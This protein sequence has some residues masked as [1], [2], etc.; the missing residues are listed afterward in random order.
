MQHSQRGDPALMAAHL[1]DEAEKTVLSIPTQSVW[2]E[3]RDEF[4][5]A[6]RLWEAADEAFADA[7]PTSAKGAIA[8][9]GALAEMLRSIPVRD[10]SL[11][12]RHVRALIAYLEKPRRRSRAA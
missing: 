6:E 8:K 11:E 1:A 5:A 12:I 3:F 4:V 7:V 10:D 2:D 9:L